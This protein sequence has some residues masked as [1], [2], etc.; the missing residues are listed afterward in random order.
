MLTGVPYDKWM[1]AAD[2]NEWLDSADWTAHFDKNAVDALKM[3][4]SDTSAT[5][6]PQVVAPGTG[7]EARGLLIRDANLVFPFGLA[8]ISF[9]FLLRI[10][11][12]LS[13]HIEVHAEEQT[14]DE[15]LANA[16]KRDEEAK[17][18]QPAAEVTL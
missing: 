13:G 15:D 1:K 6:M 17:R 8:V 4:P 5:H 16:A 18:D 10:L 9:K 3:D 14:D 7:E 2:W 12:V 11:L